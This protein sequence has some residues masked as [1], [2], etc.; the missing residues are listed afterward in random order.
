MQREFVMVDL[1]VVGVV[2][3]GVVVEIGAEEV[4]VVMLGEVDGEEVEDLLEVVEEEEEDG[5]DD[6]DVEVSSSLG[7]D[8]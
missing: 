4:F 3:V 2:A 5:V 8:V 7:S 1:R 6:L